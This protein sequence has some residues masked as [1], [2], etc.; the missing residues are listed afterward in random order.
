MSAASKV[1]QRADRGGK[2]QYLHFCTSKAS[3]LSTALMREAVVARS[4]CQYLHFC[5]SKASKLS[6]A[7]LL[8][9]EGRAS[10]AQW[11]GR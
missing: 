4:S 10:V 11:D 6:P 5:T 9:G 7:G 1:A 2:T 3:K 8:G